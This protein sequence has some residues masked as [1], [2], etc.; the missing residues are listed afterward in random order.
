MAVLILGISSGSNFCLPNV[1]KAMQKIYNV[2]IPGPT[3]HAYLAG[4]CVGLGSAFADESDPD[5][6]AVA[7]VFSRAFCST[8]ASSCSMRPSISVSRPSRAVACCS[9]LNCVSMHQSDICSS[10]SDTLQALGRPP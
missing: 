4:H 7:A 1:A 8:L 3:S 10:K 6:A 5:G 2:G 9:P